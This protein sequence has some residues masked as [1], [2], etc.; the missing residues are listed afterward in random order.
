LISSKVLFRQ[1]INDLKLV[2]SPDEISALAFAT[3]N[4]FGISRTDVISGKTVELDYSKLLPII[5]RLNQHEPLQYVLNEAWFCG[6]KFFVDPAVLIPRPETEL[7]VQEAGKLISGKEKVNIL[8]IGTGSGCIAISLSLKFPKANVIGIDISE[9]ALVVARKNAIDLRANVQ[10]LQYDILTGFPKEHTF[11][12]IV[13]NPPYVSL[14]E[15]STLKK[16]VFDYEPHLALFAAKYDDLIFYRAI[17]SVA[18]QI[19]KPNGVVAVEINER[20]GEAVCAIFQGSSLNKIQLLKDWSG[21][22]RIVTAHLL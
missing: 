10:F 11:D 3:L 14:Q 13:S 21:K 17:A 7:L 12:L 5:S 1:I 16:N 4:Y 15:K 19:L 8:D 22:D 18:K 2:E 6:R 20:L 9:S